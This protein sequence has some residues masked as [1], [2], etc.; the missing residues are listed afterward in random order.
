M[1]TMKQVLKGASGLI[2]VRDAVESALAL[3]R[4]YGIDDFPLVCQWKTF[5]VN[6]QIVM[7]DE[8]DNATMINGNV[9]GYLN[10][11]AQ[12][13]RLRLLNGSSHRFFM[14]AINDNR[15]F[16]VISGDESLLNAPV[17]LNKLQLAPGERAEI[18][19]DFSG[20]N[21]NTYY[22]KQLGTQLPSGYPGG[23]AGMMGTPGPLDEYRF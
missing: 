18:V 8:L 9:N 11:P 6:K 15:N 4:T 7:D 16:Q 2:I 1:K 10:V 5:D 19:V 3:P 21:G 14:F 17:T 13:V 23:P 12:M 20:Q 22:L